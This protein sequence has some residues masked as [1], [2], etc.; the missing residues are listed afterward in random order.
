MKSLHSIGEHKAIE[1]L[2]SKLTSHDQLVVGAGD[3][4]AVT[5]FNS[6]FDQVFTTDP[7]IE[8]VH[9]LST[10]DPF[11]VGRKAIGRAYSDLAAMG[12]EP[13][14]VLVN[15][16]APA[17]YDFDRLGRMYD[18]MM[19]IT[20]Q[21]GGTIIGGDLAKGGQ[22]ELHVFTTGVVAKDQ[23]LLRSGARVGDLVFVTGALGGSIHGKHLSFTPL[24][25]EGVFLR[26]SGQIG[27]MMDVSDG[28]SS[29]LRQIALAS[30]LGALIEE[31]LLP[32]SNELREYAPLS[33]KA[34][35]D[36]QLYG[37]EDYQLLFT[38]GGDREEEL[39]KM[40]ND[41]LIEA[42]KIGVMVEGDGVTIMRNDGRRESLSDSGFSHF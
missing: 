35:L 2:T 22:L 4:C 19:E 14:W 7:V 40:I 27:A 15:V 18:G 28:I 34:I 12:A 31:N 37:G 23:A 39:K 10:D 25:K 6:Q 36:Y 20:N 11:L 33:G 21:F 5:Q 16:V 17:E 13:Q 30:G 32:A 38:V 29:D 26:D 42:T 8:G 3:D 24:I 41:G 9:F 1:L